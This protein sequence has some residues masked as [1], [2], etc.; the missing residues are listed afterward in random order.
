MD[1]YFA[2][3]TI[4]LLALHLIY[5]PK[6]LRPLHHVLIILAAFVMVLL[7][8]AMGPE[9]DMLTQAFVGGFSAALLIGYWAGYALYHRAHYGRARF[10]PY[11]WW[12]LTSGLVMMVTGYIMFSLQNLL[13]W[14]YDYVHSIWHSCV[15]LGAWGLQRAMPPSDDKTV[16]LDARIQKQ[17]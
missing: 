16:P 13:Y 1:F 6:V 5:W 7:K 2:E 3:L 8:H 17:L 15:A 12:W 14:N 9:G 10:P 4:P 11:N